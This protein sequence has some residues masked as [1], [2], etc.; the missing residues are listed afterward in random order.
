V[1]ISLRSLSDNDILSH[2]RALTVQERTST[3]LLLSHLNEIERRRLHLKQGYQSMFDYC[4]SGL[5]YSAS[6]AMRRIRTARCIA[7]FPQAHALLESNEVNLSTISQVS[8]ILTVENRTE[9]LRRIRGRSQREV[10]AIVAEYEPR[11]AIPPDRVRT[12]VMRVPVVVMPSPERVLENS[13]NRNGCACEER[14]GT[15]SS[16][17][18]NRNGCSGDDAPVHDGV[19]DYNR[20]GCD[21]ESPATNCAAAKLERRALI[22]FTASEAFMAKLERVR[23]LAW[24]RLPSNASFEQVFELALDRLIEKEDPR[25]RN[26]RREERGRSVQTSETV[27]VTPAVSQEQRQPS[28]ATRRARHIPASVRDQVFVRDKGQC[29]YRGGNGRR[30]ASTRA[31]QVDHIQPVARG[32]AGTPDNLRLLCAYHNRLEAERMMGHRAVRDGPSPR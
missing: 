10:E 1:S 27:A 4:T 26:E 3:L 30:C 31:L 17:D 16:G 11:A 32:G 28:D 29:V 2:T 9:V 13:H 14:P 25:V 7:R 19:K 12:V 15:Q 21:A 24:H 23:S 18:H 20:N 8:R 6:A 5:G 22:Q